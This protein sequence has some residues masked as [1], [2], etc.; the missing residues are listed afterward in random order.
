MNRNIINKFFGTFLVVFFLAL[1]GAK[2]AE[3][4][5]FAKTMVRYDRM[6][7]SR[8][9]SLQVVVVPMTTQ[10]ESKIVINFGSATV[11]AGQSATTGGLGAGISGL[12]GTLTAVGSGTSIAISGLTDLAVGTTYG[13]N[14]TVGVSTPG[15]AS[16]LDTVTTYTAG[17]AVIDTATVQSYYITNDQ[18]LITANVPPTFTFTLSGNTDAFTTDL[19]ST[20]ISATSGRTVTVS[21]NAAKGWIGWVKSANQALSS[22]TTLESIGTTGTVDT[23]PSVCLMG[24]DCYLLD[25]DK[26]TTGSGTGS[27]TIEPEYNGVGTTDGGTLSGSFQPFVTRTGKTTGDVITLIAKASMLATKGAANDYTDTLTVIG[28]GNF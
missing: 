2:T 5:Q 15:T 10:T 19:S 6:M 27:L 7:Q 28:A 18:I 17:G 12:P 21:T 1:F 3:A 9:S 25:A 4:A 20:A 16:A 8:L 22:A 26:T 14:L 24:T 13:F 11:G 23:T